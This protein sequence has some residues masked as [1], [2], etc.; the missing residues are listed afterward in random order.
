MKT[1]AELE[2]YQ[3]HRLPH[4]RLEGATYFVTWDLKPGQ[5]DLTDKERDIVADSIRFF[6]NSRYDLDALV[7]MPDHVHIVLA[8]IDNWKLE[9]IIYSIKR[10]SATRFVKEF[11]RK[12]PVWR[13][14]Y[15]DHIIRNQQ[16]WEEK[17]GY[18]LTNPQRRWSDVQAYKWVYLRDA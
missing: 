3:H 18:V 13:K 7:V 10:F 6:D 9:Q 2:I 15:Y 12:S 5:S 16:D 17:V 4:W 14:E 1:L 8:P 11:G